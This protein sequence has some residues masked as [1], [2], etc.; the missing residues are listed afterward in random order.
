[1]AKRLADLFEKRLSQL[2]RAFARTELAARG[3]DFADVA[4]YLYARVQR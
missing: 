1:M 4:Q 2:E 3:W